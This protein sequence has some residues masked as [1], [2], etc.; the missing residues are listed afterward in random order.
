MNN[1]EEVL[2]EVVE[3]ENKLRHL[4]R[5]TINLKSRNE[6]TMESIIKFIEI[7]YREIKNSCDTLTRTL[8]KMHRDLFHLLNAEE[9][10]QEKLIS[11]NEIPY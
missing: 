11:E 1:S 5:E 4:I 3:Y 7:E 8:N 9:I 2:K 10:L 6:Q